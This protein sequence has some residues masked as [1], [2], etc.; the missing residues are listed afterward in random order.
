MDP[1][2][3]RGAFF[4]IHLWCHRAE[5]DG[6]MAMDVVQTSVF[7]GSQRMHAVLEHCHCSES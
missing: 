2:C 1:P 4:V 7:Q 6:L 3:Y 5:G